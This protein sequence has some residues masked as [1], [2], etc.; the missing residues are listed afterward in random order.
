MKPASELSGMRFTRWTVV[1]R[2]LPNVKGNTRWRCRCDCGAEAFVTAIQLKRGGSK[3]CGC[4]HRERSSDAA[5]THGKS[6][7]RVYHAWIGM[8]RRCGDETRADY[9]RYGGRGIVV[10]ERWHSFE[11]FYAD[12]GDPG[13]AMTL[14][15]R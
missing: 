10:C 6:G 13:E 4:L 11:N 1:E 2:V 8:I 15:R 9:H 5:R 7:T 12:M 3:S 14:E